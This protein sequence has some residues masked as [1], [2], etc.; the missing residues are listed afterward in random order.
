MHFLVYICQQQALLG[1]CDTLLMTLPHEQVQEFHKQWYL[2]KDN[3][4]EIFLTNGKTSLLAFNNKD[5]CL[6]LTRF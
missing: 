6:W 4:L 5:V 3:A 2:L 1:N